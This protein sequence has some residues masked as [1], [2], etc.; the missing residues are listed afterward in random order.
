MMGE[1]KMIMGEFE[2]T[3]TPVGKPNESRQETI[4]VILTNNE[5]YSLALCEYVKTEN[6]DKANLEINGEYYARHG[7]QSVYPDDYPMAVRMYNKRYGIY[8]PKYDILTP[9][10]VTRLY[11][12]TNEQAKRLYNIK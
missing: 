4:Y 8:S 5:K 2:K 1:W 12:E 3:I 9:L 10:D 6:I 7:N 11:E